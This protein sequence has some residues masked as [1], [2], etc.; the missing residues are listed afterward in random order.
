MLG[1]HEAHMGGR[2]MP[3]EVKQ[4]VRLP[5]LSTMKGDLTNIY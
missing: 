5:L 3:L 2:R 4:Q 1:K